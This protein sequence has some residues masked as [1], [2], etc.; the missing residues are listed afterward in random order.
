MAR[1]TAALDPA[2][3]PTFGA[4]LRYLRRR[5]RLTQ[6]D[7]AI[8]V[9][10]STGQISRLE[11]N[12][13]LPNPATLQALFVPALGLEHEPKLAARLLE[14]A[15]AAHDQ[16]AA[17]AWLPEPATAV[18]TQLPEPEPR[19]AEIEPTT[20]VAPPLPPAGPRAPM[21]PAPFA[22]RLSRLGS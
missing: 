18:A 15:Q 1:S 8:A 9:G 17:D 2:A 3:F 5:Q 19:A 12:Q 22:S 7:L 4:L 10:Y 21:Q 6:I 14:L 11:Q 16:R 13:R 20:P